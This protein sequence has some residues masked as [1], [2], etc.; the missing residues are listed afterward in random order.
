MLDIQFIRENREQAATKAQQKGY[1]V[2]VDT[3]LQ[4]DERRRDLVTQIEAVRAKRNDLAAML[5]K[6]NP[7]LSKSP[8]VRR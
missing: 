2:D 3:L 4:L 1:P 7:L 5:K 8:K 6:P